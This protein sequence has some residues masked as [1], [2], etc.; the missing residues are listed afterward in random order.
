MNRI[1][2][3]VHMYGKTGV[4]TD[5]VE[6]VVDD[7]IKH[8]GKEINFSTS[9]GLGKSVLFIN[10]LYRRAKEDPTIKLKIMTALSLEI[11]KGKSEL[12][13]RMVDPLAE[14]I[15]GGCPELDYMIDLRAGKM[16]E[17]V[18]LWEFYSKAGSIMTLPSQQRRHLPSNYTHVSRDAYFTQNTNVFGQMMACKEINGKMMY[19]M[20]CNTDIN[21]TANLFLNQGKAE[22][23]KMAIIG[24]I[25][26]NLPFMYGDAVYE[27]DKFDVFLKGPKYNYRLFGPPKDPVTIKDHM[28]GLNISALVKDGGTLQV[29][30]GALGDAIV[31]GLDMR[32]THNDTYNE[33]I[34]EAGLTGRYKDLIDEF[35]GTGTFKEGLY[36]SSE[37]F[38]DAFM[39]LYKKGILKRKVY[40]D[41]PLMKLVNEGKVS[42]ENIPGDILELLYEYDGIHLRLREKDFNMLTYYGILKE[43]LT[44]KNGFIYDGDKEYNA[45]IH[46]KKNLEE[47]K[48]L[49]GK[50][51]KN[52]QI[53]LGGFYLGPESFYKAL[54]EM[55]EEERSQFGMSGVEKV[56]QL[57]GDAELRSLQRKDGR[58]VNS[59]MMV[60]L[61]GSIVSDQLEDGRIVSG[62]G[63]QFNFVSMAHAIPDGKVIM[64]IRATRGSGKNTRSNII[65]KYGHC[66]VP[67]YWRDIVVTEYGIAH[68]RGLSEEQVTEELI[69]IADSRF[70]D[71]LIRQAKKH[72]RIN[73]DWVLP[74]EYRNNYPEKVEAFIKK[75]QAEGYFKQ[76]PYGT[77]I[78]PEEVVLG[79][80]LKGFKSSIESKPVSTILKL[81]A[82]FLRSV[83][84]K[85]APYLKRMDLEKPANFRERFQQKTVLVALRN[86]GRL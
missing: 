66:T 18:E 84:E 55:P 8:V 80:A 68:L 77:D 4:I 13:R 62:V 48:K 28:I 59:G 2:N 58:F 73:E 42:E 81:G 22:G 30:I 53:I 26:E 72:G 57:Y 37:M 70:Q 23:K 10:E 29:G 83:P 21:V 67:K 40:D 71:D 38:V 6:K 7:V 16:P 34:N 25:N 1:D 17:N 85:A 61:N 64:A 12:E 47:I 9:L 54:N 27:A 60:T 3:S 19:S 76:F 31:A 5:D 33:I 36:G 75:H 51:L 50:K 56:N 14:R 78:T 35:G 41:L 24:E 52:G 82:E 86:T 65:L 43:G 15:F 46:D 74:E 49:L 32:H 45:D 63:G 69:K 20:G 11:P 79:G 39:Q 44:Y